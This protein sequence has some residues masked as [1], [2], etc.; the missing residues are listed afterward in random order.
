MAAPIFSAFSKELNE[1]VAICLG[2]RTTKAVHLRRHNEGFALLDYVLLETPRPEKGLTP[3][4]L[5]A[6]FKNIRSAL[7]TEVKQAVLV[8]G[9]GESLLRNV[10]LPA[11]PP[12]ELRRMLKFNSSRYLNQELSD[13]V[14]DCGVRKPQTAAGGAPTISVTGTVKTLVAGAKNRFVEDLQSAAEEAGWVVDQITL[15]QIGLANAARLAMP[16]LMQREVVA[17]V[18]LGFVSTTI[19]ILVDGEPQLTRVVSIGADKFTSGLASALSVSY[20]AAEGVKLAMP[21]KVQ[22]KLQSVISPLGRE[23]RAAIDFFEDQEVKTVTKVFLTGGSARSDFIVQTL[24]AEL[25]TPCKRWNPT[26]FLA[27]ELP[28]AKGRELERDATQLAA[29]IGAGVTCL[30]SK[31]PRINLLADQLAAAQARR[32]DPVRRGFQL[33][34]AVVVLL[35]GW[36]GLLGFKLSAKHAELSRSTAEFQTFEKE[37]KA[38]TQFSK[39]SADVEYLITNLVQ[40]STNRF[41][42][43]RPLSAL[44]QSMVDGIQVVR[45]SFEQNVVNVEGIKPTREDDKPV[46]GKPGFSTEKT[47]L[48]IQAKN[49]GDSANVDKFIEAIAATSHFRS[50]LRKSN[51]VILKNRLPTQVDPVD[52]SISFTMFTIECIYAERVLGHE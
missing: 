43:A 7:G 20:P 27:V 13:F 17:M 46:P 26:G 18:D 25:G 23:L 34:M 29:A 22:D 30:D 14:F 11:L 33:V 36:A 21:E 35:L 5:T 49:F 47:I 51:P 8:I 1:I 39:K 28:P 19:S 31:L 32:R 42:W 37:A 50:S 38:A 44:Q 4:A 10:D 16:D 24:H 45:I 3:E 41:L 12:V 52:P 15:S 2:T 48:T 40:H 6:H 9:M